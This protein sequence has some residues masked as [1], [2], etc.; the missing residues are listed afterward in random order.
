MGQKH[1]AINEFFIFKIPYGVKGIRIINGL[2][3][4]K[5]LFYANNRVKE[6]YIGFLAQID[7]IKHGACSTIRKFH[8]TYQ[9]TIDKLITLNDT[10]EPQE[11]YFSNVI[12]RF[13]WEDNFLFK[14]KKN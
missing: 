13:N 12:H 10:M 11:I 3:K 7:P 9:T 8:I 6:I 5:K 4:N 1:S 2:A 14:Y